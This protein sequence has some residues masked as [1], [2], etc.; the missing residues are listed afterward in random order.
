MLKKKESVSEEAS[1][2][3]QLKVAD[4]INTAVKKTPIFVKGSPNQPQLV[5]RCTQEIKGKSR[6]KPV[7]NGSHESSEVLSSPAWNPDWS[8]RDSDV[9][10][11]TDRINPSRSA[12]TGKKLRASRE[13]SQF[14]MVVMNLQKSLPLQHGIHTEV[15][16]T[17]IF[18]ERQ[19]N[20]APACQQIQA[21]N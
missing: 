9:L 6:S 14:E 3:M 1:L 15:E 10:G 17:Q 19:S 20:S 12:D 18:W 2:Q 5:S 8:R 11:K 7:R 21:R 13:A 16:E 4:L